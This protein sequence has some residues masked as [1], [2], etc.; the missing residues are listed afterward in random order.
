MTTSFPQAAEFTKL[1]ENMLGRERERLEVKSQI[2]GHGATDMQEGRVLNRIMRVVPSGWEFEGDQRHAEVIT[3]TLNLEASKAVAT[4]GEDA[5]KEKEEELHFTLLG[6]AEELMFLAIGR[7]SNFFDARQARHIQYAVKE[8]CR[9]MSAPTMG[10][11]RQMM[12]LGRY[13]KGRP[14]AVA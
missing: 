11:W 6:S 3:S 13:V 5:K 12:R 9:T 14:C 1:F 8:L 7:N 4:R 2:I 10:H